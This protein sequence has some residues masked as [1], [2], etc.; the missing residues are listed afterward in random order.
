M[1]RQESEIF[2]NGFIFFCVRYK[3]WRGGSNEYQ[4]SMFF[5]EIKKKIMY[6]PCKP[7]FYYKKVGF[8]GV[9]II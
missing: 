1:I 5:A 9:K 3:Q 8:K 2:S 4:Q 6:T 7:H